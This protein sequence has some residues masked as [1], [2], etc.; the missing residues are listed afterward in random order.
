MTSQLF[1]FDLEADSAPLDVRR[2]LLSPNQLA[3]HLRRLQADFD[4]RSQELYRCESCNG[5]VNSVNDNKN[6]VE[7]ER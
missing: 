5:F 3:A 1:L 6:C 4:A 7:C 2:R